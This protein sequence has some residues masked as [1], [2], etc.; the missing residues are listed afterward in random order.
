M[1]PASRK[2]RILSRYRRRKKPTTRKSYK[3]LS[4]LFAV[5]TI[6]L[7]TALI[8][9]GYVLFKYFE[10]NYAWAIEESTFAAKLNSNTSFVY[11]TVDDISAVKPL[12]SRIYFVIA[13]KNANKL[14]IHNINPE[15]KLDLPGRF[16]EE[17]LSN[18]PLLSSLDNKDYVQTLSSAILK[19]FR[20]SVSSYVLVNKDFEINADKLIIGGDSYQFYN[21]A[22]LAGINQNIRTGYS[23]KDLYILSQLA[24][25]LP[26]DRKTL[27]YVGSPS[28]ID[29]DYTDLN[30][31][32]ILNIE[33]PSIAVINATGI[34][35]FATFAAEVLENHGARIVG[36]TSVDKVYDTSLLIAADL[37]LNSV[38]LISGIFDIKSVSSKEEAADLGLSEVDRA[39]IVVVLGFDTAERLY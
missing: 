7:L 6:A 28:D 16:G 1:K 39:D 9:G 35:G 13:D 22:T 38:A 33:K 32:S 25:L 31:E 18:I 8:F 37:K 29:V 20:Y 36:I 27:E 11:L 10:E 24:D 5:I 4:K 12:I 19:L 2:V 30:F 34:E 17:S 26:D 3:K 15:L 23:L 14:I 21:P